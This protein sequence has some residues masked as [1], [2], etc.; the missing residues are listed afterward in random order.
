MAFFDLP[1]DQLRT[2]LP[3]RTEPGDFDSFWADTLDETRAFPLDARVEAVDFVLRTMETF[4]FTFKGFG[5]HP[6]K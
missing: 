2:Y 5:C 6:I 3:E 4:E 1:L